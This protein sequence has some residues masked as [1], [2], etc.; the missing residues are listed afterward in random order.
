[1][2]PLSNVGSMQN[3]SK[4]IQQWHNLPSDRRTGQPNI[5]ELHHEEGGRQGLMMASLS[6]IRGDPEQCGMESFSASGP[7]GDAAESWVT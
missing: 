6:T 7:A 3:D 5:T 4:S 2:W 1:M